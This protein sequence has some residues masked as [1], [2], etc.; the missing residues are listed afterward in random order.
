MSFT[1]EKTEQI[2]KYIL[3]KI[4]NNQDK[5]AKRTA[6]A[7][8]IS[9]NTAYRY[10]RDLEKEGIIKKV[11]G[12]K[13]KYELVQVTNDFYFRPKSGEKLQEDI[14]YRQ[15]I[16]KYIK[17][18]PDNVQRIWVYSFTEMM[19]NAI[20]HSDAE[21]ILC[22]ISQNYMTTL[23]SIADNGVGIFKKIKE[24]YNFPTLD[25][26]IR[27]L[28]KGKLTT[29][30]NNHSGEGIFFTSRAL[31]VFAVVS[32]GKIFSHDRY[33]E[34]AKDLKEIDSLQDF[35]MNNGTM[36][37]MQL[38]NFSNK[39]LREVFDMYS[40]QVDG[41]VKTNIAIRNLFEIYPVS[42]SQARRLCNRFEK[43]KEVV[44][45]FDGID[46]IGQGFAHEIFVV[47]QNK[48]PD[49]K[50]IPINTLPNVEK[51]INHVKNTN[52]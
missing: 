31:D 40:D 45:D 7:F 51:M 11:E 17:E 5:I 6:T 41:F 10:I 20:E 29:D 12:N 14:I 50:L 8:N 39:V 18:L 35:K 26:A 49:V 30:V 48:H 16:D 43:F 38:S 46:D 2:K 37:V 13:R 34:I 28:F 33:V 47:F 1:K 22:R 15:Y 9:L 23:I 4:E 24:Y 27:E 25:D 19:N 3:E 52:S 21:L 32:D 36:V 44:L 42:R